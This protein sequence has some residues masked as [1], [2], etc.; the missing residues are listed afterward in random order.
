MRRK[1]VLKSFRA[2]LTA[3]YAVFFTLLLAGFSGFLYWLL[4]HNLYAR[5]DATLATTAQTVTRLFG[6]ELEEMH[7]NARIA[8]NEIVRELKLP[9]LIAVFEGAARLDAAEP[10][11]GTHL[12][13]VPGTS[14]LAGFGAHGARMT[15]TPFQW[16]GRSFTIAVVEPLDAVA[17]QLEALRHVFYVALPAAILIAAFGGFLLAHKSIAPVVSISEQAEL[18]TDRNLHARLAAPGAR[19]EFAR[20][21]TVIN[22]LLGRLDQSFERMRD[23]MAD[24]SHELR[25]PLAIIRGEADVALARNRQPAEYRESLAIMQD[26]AR[27]LTRLVEDLLN[28]AR[29]DA[30]HRQL[31]PEEIYLNDLLDECCRPAHSQARQKGVRLIAP[32]SVDLPLRGDPE[33]LRRLIANLL[34]NAIRYT[35]SG[36]QVEAKLEAAGNMARLT[37]SDT[38]VGIPPEAIG[39]IFERFYRVDKSRSRAE[40]GFGLG[41]AIVKWIV[42][43]HHGLIEVASRQNQGTT[44]TVTLPRARPSDSPAPRRLNSSQ[45]AL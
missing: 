18:I 20:L 2:Q 22:E 3:W 28:L 29:A 14:L 13:L 21:T 15:V 24:A 45:R 7:G 6:D 37:V 12:R 43:A 34:D 10:I 31:Q 41:L 16:K 38:G 5:V 27:R 23:F 19:L 11:R 32:Q 17:A 35:P 33:L 36:G 1:P 40:G 30:G 44:F 42:E 4:E 9:S 26:E 25:T 39:K 8:A